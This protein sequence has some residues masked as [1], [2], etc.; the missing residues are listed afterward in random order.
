M[1]KVI[2]TISGYFKVINLPIIQ[3]MALGILTENGIVMN[4]APIL[5]EDF[6]GIVGGLK[7]KNRMNEKITQL[8]DLT[9]RLQKI[10]Q[11]KTKK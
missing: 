3:Q 1:G 11:Y 2:G 7:R 6:N 4:T 10:D 5:I 9:K 8:I